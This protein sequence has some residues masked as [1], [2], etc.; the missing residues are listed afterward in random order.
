MFLFLIHAG[1]QGGAAEG[2]WR[3]MLRCFRWPGAQN[4]ACLGLGP[5]GQ[6]EAGGAAWEGRMQGILSDHEPRRGDRACAG[7]PRPAK[8]GETLRGASWVLLG[9]WQSARALKGQCHLGWT[10]V[11]VGAPW[12][13][14]GGLREFCSPCS[15]CARYG[16]FLLVLFL[17]HEPLTPL[18]IWRV[19]WHRPVRR[20]LLCAEAPAVGHP[21][22]QGSSSQVA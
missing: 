15:W 6:H 16:D 11:C 12:E 7:G 13:R 4:R 19:L 1:Q 21:G 9:A 3:Q 10:R 14:R 20:P 5:S 2:R 8:L 18:S 17:S 22:A